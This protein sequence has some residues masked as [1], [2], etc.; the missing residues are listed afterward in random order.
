MVKKIILSL[1]VCLSVA[2]IAQDQSFSLQGSFSKMDRKPSRLYLQY[3]QGN[4]W[5]K[6]SSDVA[7]GNYFF[8]GRISEPTLASLTVAG[9]AG[10]SSGLPQI[11][12]LFL[13]PGTI[14]ILHT[15]T[16]PNIMVYGSLAQLDY[17]AL[18]KSGAPFRFRLD[19]LYTAYRFARKAK[20]TNRMQELETEIEAVSEEH[21]EKV[22]R[23]FAAEHPE[24]PVALYALKE[25]AGFPL[26]PVKTEPLFLKLAPGLQN[27]PSAKELKA[28]I[29][30]AKITAI[31][32]IA[33]D[34]TQN[35]T[36]GNPLTLSSLRGNY[37]L[38]DFWASWCGPCRYEN[39]NLV[40]AYEAYKNKG[41]TI[42]GVSLDQ[43]DGRTAWL[44][45]IK[46][47]KLNWYQVSDLQFWKNSVAVQYG[48]NAIPQNILLDP[49]GKI[50]AKNLR[51]KDLLR[52]L[53]E[54]MP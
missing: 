41:F 40:A 23:K 16:F 13:E 17:A 48:I 44:K 27:Y 21:R 28:K 4:Q 32:Q 38:I 30:I 14:R 12:G 29:D 45:A 31:G 2:A 19:T 39:P 22:L 52:K 20:D 46:D 6:D 25:S 9:T 37:L 24:S 54:L 26:D 47:D 7:N 8:S 33:P 43:P 3:Q 18:D 53:Q 34:F 50:I 5:I 11:L 1:F 51:G 42:L 35:D 15:D 10:S 49:Q 36:L